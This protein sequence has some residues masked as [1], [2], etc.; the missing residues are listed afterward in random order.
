MV[1]QPSVHGFSAAQRRVFVQ[2]GGKAV[3]SG[4]LRAIQLFTAEIT[5]DTLVFIGKGELP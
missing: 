4:K 5:Q 2:Y 3:F 1:F